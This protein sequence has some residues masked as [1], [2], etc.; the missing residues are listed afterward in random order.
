MEQLYIYSHK[1]S[2]RL[3]YILKLIFNELMGLD[4]KFTTN[5]EE[6]RS[7]VHP[8]FAYTNSP[9][10]DAL[11]LCCKNLL[12]ETDIRHQELQFVDFKD[13]PS[14]FPVYHKKSILPFDMFAASFLFISRYEEYLPHKKDHH[15]R[16]V[17]AES[18]AFQK[19]FLQKPVINIWAKELHRILKEKYPILPEYKGR[20]KFTP[21]YD[22]DIA[23]SFKNKGLT[24]NFGG[25]MRDILHFDWKQVKLRVQVLNHKVKDPYDTYQIQHRWTKKYKLNPIYF[26]LFGELGPFDKNISFINSNFQNLIKD[27]RDHAQIGIHPSYASNENPKLLKNELNNLSENVHIDIT[28]SRQHF[29]KLDLPSTYRNLLNLGIQHDYTMGFASQVGFRAG[30]CESFFFYDLDLETETKLRVHPFAVMDGTLRD[31]LKTDSDNAK[32][33]ISN[34]IKEVKAVDGHFISLWHNESLNNLDKWSGWLE[35]YEHLLKEATK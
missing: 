23:W 15:K 24:R 17:A 25:L 7:A 30:I 13:I 16:F 11:F 29:L 3:Q 22:I 12:F 28:R 9:P 33:I 20:Y 26:I 6:F 21:T 10:N 4:Y 18:L 27:L 8:K 32:N 31:Y 34:L 1:N 5:I 2:K 14:A 19:G 35:V